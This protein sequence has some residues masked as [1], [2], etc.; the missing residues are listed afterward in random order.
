MNDTSKSPVLTEA[1]DEEAVDQGSCLKHA[2]NL[3]P[4]VY[5]T[6]VVELFKL[7]GP[8]VINV[9]G[10]S[11]G[12][13]LSLT[14]DTLISQTY[15]SGNLKRVGV[16]LQ[17]GVLILLLACFPCWAILLNTEVLLLLVKQSPAVARL[18]QLYV[19]I[20]MPSLPAAFMYQLQA[21]YLQNQSIIWPQ[22]ITGVI[23]NIL[24]AVINYVLIYLLD[25]GIEGSA[26]ANSVTQFLLAFILFVYIYARGL[27]KKTWGGWSLDCL[28]EWGPFIK[29]AIPSMLMLCLEWWILEIGAFLAGIISETE[30]GAQSVIYELCV[31]AYM[32]PLGLSCAASVR[33]GQALGAGKVEAAKLA[34]KVPVVCGFCMACVVAALI[35]CA[36]DYIAYIFTTEREIIE[37]VSEVV[38][39]YS[40]THIGDAAAGIN[41]GVVRGAGKQSAG[42]LFNLVGYYAIGLPIGVSLMFPAK[43]GIKGL[44]I[45]LLIS[46]FTQTAVFATYLSKLN[47]HEAAVEAQKRSWGLV[48]AGVQINHIDSKEATSAE[49]V[50]ETPDNCLQD[51]PESSPAAGCEGQDLWVV[52]LSLS[53]RALTLLPL[54][55]EAAV[56]LGP[57]SCAGGEPHTV[58]GGPV[59]TYVGLCGV[60][61]A[62][63]NAFCSF[64]VASSSSVANL[65]E[66]PVR[67]RCASQT[68]PGLDW[69]SGLVLNYAQRRLRARLR[70]GSG[71]PVLSLIAGPS[72]T[73]RGSLETAN[74]HKYTNSE[75][76]FH[77]R[78]SSCLHC[79]GLTPQA[80]VAPVVDTDHQY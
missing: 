45:G 68:L 48:N 39:V 7:A 36:K 25:L 23:G 80:R 33:V 49:P 77:R 63:G 27:H 53:L 29:L 10:L 58:V 51:Q 35:L 46:S 62:L 34:A 3:I 75:P 12:T 79:S 30:L 67:A 38:I 73:S 47:W 16:I 56:S 6:E 54:L 41:G 18:S 69:P 40:F 24:N 15:G 37:R 70:S 8:V 43:M 2:K 60:S 28:Q 9:T 31:I 11:I 13:G 17:R 55:R 74:H 52:F 14:C 78:S 20:F 4:A 1:D 19:N 32:L 21:R 57:W 72:C 42:A 59:G 50:C 5:R 64:C 76:R 66:G 26:A 44:W 65:S 71:G 22:V 61:A